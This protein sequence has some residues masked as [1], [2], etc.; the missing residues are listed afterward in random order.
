MTGRHSQERDRGALSPQD[1]NDPQ[2]PC[3]LG[4]A[5]NAAAHL[6]FARQ[7]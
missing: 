5:A 3:S 1:V 7:D 2:E 4:Y 6:A